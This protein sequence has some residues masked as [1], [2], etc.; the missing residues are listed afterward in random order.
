[1]MNSKNKDK[2]R[3][4][5]LHVFVELLRHLLHVIYVAGRGIK[6]GASC[7]ARAENGR[8]ISQVI[9]L[10]FLNLKSMKSLHAKNRWTGLFSGSLLFLLLNNYLPQPWNFPP[11]ACGWA[12]AT[13]PPPL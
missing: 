2:E 11:L 9:S 12:A 8:T 10:P 7:A 5:G 3:S 13:P 4:V 6:E 1:M